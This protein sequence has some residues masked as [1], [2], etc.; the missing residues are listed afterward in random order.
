MITNAM[1][2]EL[3]TSSNRAALWTWPTRMFALLAACAAF[4]LL[5]NPAQ[6]AETTPFVTADQPDYPPGSIV[7]ITGGGFTP[8]ETVQ[9]QVVHVGDT[10]SDNDTSSAHE[11]W[12]VTADADGA[13]ITTWDVP[14]D[15][16]ELGATLL[17]TAAGQTS[18]LTAE[19]TFTDGTVAVTAATGGSAISA[20]STSGSYT[21]LTG[22][23]IA[24]QV[25]GDIHTGTIILNAPAGFV[26][27]AAATV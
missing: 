12:Q 2:G 14:F 4:W 22:P 9:L 3:E 11:P 20:D 18:G 1:A 27:N 13:L 23:V 21:T 17:L 24:E 19:V 16:D 6:A 26:F 7:S 8:G 5:L 10:N 25:S 15:E